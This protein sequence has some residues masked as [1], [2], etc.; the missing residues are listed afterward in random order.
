MK[1]FA[2]L[3]LLAGAQAR[4]HH[5]HPHN[6]ELLATLPDVRPE[7]PTEADIQAHENARSEAAKIQY[8]WYAWDHRW[9]E[10]LLDQINED[11]SF[12]I[13][14]SQSKRNDRARHTCEDLAGWIKYATNEFI[15]KVEGKP[16]GALN[17]QDSHNI[18]SLIFQ[19]V[20][21]EDY[22]KGLG[23]PVDEDL[24]LAVNR[25]KAL[26]KLYLFEQK[27]GEDYLS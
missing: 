27:G 18:A 10:H 16:E 20:R 4:H 24:V 13:S 11:V 22:M 21:L 1:F 26:Q 2:A 7:I 5:H 17:E 14:F 23:M 8:N 6:Q 19:D 12:G 15:R 9:T 25:L 3:A